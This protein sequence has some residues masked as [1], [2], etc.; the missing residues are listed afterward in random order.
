MASALFNVLADP[1]KAVAA[2]AGTQ[3]G[4][5]VHPEVLTVMKEVGVD[6]TGVR[7]QLLTQ[8]L[9]EGA[10][11]LVTMGCGDECP[12]VP[13][14]DR[15]DWPLPD[16]KGQPLERIREIR[17]DVQRRVSELIETRGWQRE[18]Q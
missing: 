5:A 6:L 8:S 1:A 4:T 17:E 18:K 13:G 10:S 15:D 9:A 16:P 2:S 11:L 14:L 12:Y 3:P 7:P